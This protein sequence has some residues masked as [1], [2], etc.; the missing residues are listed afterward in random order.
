MYFNKILNQICTIAKKCHFFAKE[1]HSFRSYSHFGEDLLLRGFLGDKWSLD[2]MG[3]WVDIGAHHPDKLSNT[4]TFYRNGWRGIS[5][6]ASSDAIAS[7]NRKRKRDIN[8]NVDIGLQ[9]GILPRGLTWIGARFPS[10]CN[11]LT[12][13]GHVLNRIAPRMFIK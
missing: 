10:V 5:V 8:V 1:L 11:L 4:K 9:S 6:D 7:F 2:Y 13:T 12:A 3:F